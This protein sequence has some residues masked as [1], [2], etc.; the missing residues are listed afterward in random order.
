MEPS[1]IGL[2]MVIYTTMSVIKA[3][4]GGST[5]HGRQCGRRTPETDHGASPVWRVKS[6]DLNRNM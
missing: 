1:F 2:A 4:C 5:T 6:G 3:V